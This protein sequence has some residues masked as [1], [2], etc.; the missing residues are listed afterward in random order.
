[1]RPTSAEK[2]EPTMTPERIKASMLVRPVSFARTNAI[3][4]ATTPN[5]NAVPTTAI[6]E[7]ESKMPRTPP[8][9]APAETPAIS[10]P[11]KGLRKTPCIAAPDNES[12]IPHRVTIRIRGRRTISIATH[13]ESEY[14]LVAWTGELVKIIR[15]MSATGTGYRPSVR[16]KSMRASMVPT[17]TN[18]IRTA[19]LVH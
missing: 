11:T 14:G 15:M 6:N 7:N 17:K 18:K 4:S 16:E 1:M 13:R 8:N 3:R 12:P 2:K 5:A 9:D 19:D 10:G